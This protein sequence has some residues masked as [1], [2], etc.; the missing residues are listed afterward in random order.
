MIQTIAL[1]KPAASAELSGSKLKVVETL[2]RL[3]ADAG[4]VEFVQ[5]KKRCRSVDAKTLRASV[6]QLASEKL[7]SVRKAA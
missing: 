1:R 3:G 4:P 6:R 5:L 7:V 2:K